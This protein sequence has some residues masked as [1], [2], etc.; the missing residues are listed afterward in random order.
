[1]V[2]AVV[3]VVVVAVVRLQGRRRQGRVRV[4]LRRWGARV[5]PCLLVGGGLV[6]SGAGGG[7][8]AEVQLIIARALIG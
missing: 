3:A 8:R 6:G 1:M 7:S 4:R 2:V 5:L